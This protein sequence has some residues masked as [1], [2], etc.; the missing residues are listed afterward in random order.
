MPEEIGNIKNPDQLVSIVDIYEPKKVTEWIISYCDCLTKPPS[1]MSVGALGLLSNWLS[2][3]TGL[4][5]AD[6]ENMGSAYAKVVDR[7]KLDINTLGI[8]QG[9]FVLS[10]H[11]TSP[12]TKA[13]E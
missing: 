12:Y 2:R 7:F 11:Q 9:L 13:R 1:P 5:K 4:E 8:G 6:Y 10:T 3:S